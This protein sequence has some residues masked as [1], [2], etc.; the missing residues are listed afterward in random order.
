MVRGWASRAA[1]RLASA[2][3]RPERNPRNV[4][5]RHHWREMGAI[6]PPSPVLAP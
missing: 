2:L 3:T 1:P 6:E 5:A 4:S